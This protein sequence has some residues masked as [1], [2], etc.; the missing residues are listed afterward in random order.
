MVNTL[1]VSTWVFHRG[2]CVHVTH[3]KLVTGIFQYSCSPIG[4]C[5]IHV[6][7]DCVS[8]QCQCF[9]WKCSPRHLTNITSVCLHF[10]M[11]MS[12]KV[13]SMWLNVGLGRGQCWKNAQYKREWPPC[14][15]QLTV[16]VPQSCWEGLS[17]TRRRARIPVGERRRGGAGALG[18]R[19]PAPVAGG[20]DGQLVFSLKRIPHALILTELCS[21]FSYQNYARN[22][23]KTIVESY[24]LQIMCAMSWNLFQWCTILF[25][26]SVLH[27]FLKV[28]T[29]LQCFFQHALSSGW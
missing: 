6:P 27:G 20:A 4:T 28:S 5:E 19:R 9:V 1:G 7:S 3:S 25:F 22:C 23:V 15:V 10:H 21:H 29:S 18:A 24:L 2:T 8:S 13:Q 14:S 16:V 26:K 12:F 11:M 17:Q